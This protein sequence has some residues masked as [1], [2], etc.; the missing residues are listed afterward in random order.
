MDYTIQML[1][2]CIAGVV[3]GIAIIRVIKMYH[4]INVMDRKLNLIIA[5]LGIDYVSLSD[6]VKELARQGR[7]IEAIKAYREETGKGLAEA[8]EAVEEWLRLE[9]DKPGGKNPASPS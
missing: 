1:L 8:K 7:K 6:R 9:E 3:L 2:A 4:R 5:S